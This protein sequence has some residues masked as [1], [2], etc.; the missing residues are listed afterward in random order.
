MLN[1]NYIQATYARAARYL[2][3]G[4][5]V[6]GA[7]YLFYLAMTELL[8]LAPL[9]A[10]TVAFGI[11]VAMTYLGNALWA[12]RRTRSHLQSAPRYV[13]AYAVGYGVQL[14]TI[15]GL[16]RWLSVPH[17]LA[18]L[19]AMGCAAVAIFVLLNAWVFAAS[20]G[21]KPSPAPS[22]PRR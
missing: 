12:F 5:S 8:G 18:Q 7:L 19:V 9:V 20:A 3:V 2:V 16:T 17:Q 6:N 11:G 1:N 15:F 4:A 13:A 10:T 22:A 21:K 14:G